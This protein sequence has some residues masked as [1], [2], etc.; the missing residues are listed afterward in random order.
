M[1]VLVELAEVRGRLLFVGEGSE[2]G[3]LVL[4]V[5][6][7]SGGDKLVLDVVGSPGE[8]VGVSGWSM[9]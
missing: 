3:G 2:G 7:S 4:V 6:G 8:L 5:V 1:G 9:V